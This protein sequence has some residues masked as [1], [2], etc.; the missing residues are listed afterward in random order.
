[1]GCRTK[2]TTKLSPTATAV[3]RRTWYERRQ[4]AHQ[5]PLE[6][7]LLPPSWTK[8]ATIACQVVK[9]EH[10]VDASASVHRLHCSCQNA[11][12]TS[13]T[14]VARTIY[15]RKQGAKIANAPVHRTGRE[16][17]R[18]PIFKPVFRIPFHTPNGIVVTPIPTDSCYAGQGN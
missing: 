13:A 5:Q 11:N 8:P 16:Y 3:L 9:S 6:G 15:A 17:L 18:A 4:R 7:V 14:K 12:P 10:R 2:Q 1:M